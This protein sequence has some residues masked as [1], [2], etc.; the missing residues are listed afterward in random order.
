MNIQKKRDPALFSIILAMIILLAAIPSASAFTATLVTPA[1]PAVALHPGDQISI[2]INNLNI[3]DVVTYKLTSANM[4]TLGNTISL[5]S[6]NMPFAFGAGTATTTLATTGIAGNVQLTVT[7]LSDSTQ[8]IKTGPSP[9]VSNN[10][11][12]KDNYD[13]SITGTKS[14]SAIGIDY[15]VTGTVSDAGANPSTLTL[16]LVNVNSGTL[17]IEVLDGA[18]SRLLQTITITP[19]PIPGPTPDAGDSGPS[20]PSAPE[21]PAAPQAMLAPPGISPTTVTLQHNPEGQVLASYVVATDP[22]AGFTS[23]LDVSLGTT[24]VSSTGQ[25]VAELSV[26]P[27]DPAVVTDVAAAQGGVFSFSGLSVEC[28]PSGTQFVGGSATISFSLTQEQWADA[29]GAVN[30]NTQAMTIQFY[31][32]AAKSWVEVPTIVDPVTH[33]VSAQVTHFSMYALFYKKPAEGVSTSPQTYGSLMSP[34]PTSTMPASTTTPVKSMLAPPSTTE[35]PG[36][37]GIVV[38][39]V[40]GFVGLLIAR[41]KQ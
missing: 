40:V 35:T 36:L 16:T 2:Q 28:G 25:P 29:L 22:A 11:V 14:G 20:G 31:D 3:G 37:P 33:T 1:D 7:K 17:T 34:T 39:G 10:N 38:I 30:G 4:D 9:I 24:V 32:P 12:Y 41:K 21:A 6:V 13:I 27:L 15:K 23:A 19:T 18:T 26:T 8:V 5:S